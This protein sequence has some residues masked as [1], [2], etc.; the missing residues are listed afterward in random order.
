MKKI[1]FA[2]LLTSFISLS[3]T[4]STIKIYN[5]SDMVSINSSDF[6]QVKKLKENDRKIKEIENQS[7][8]VRATVF[9][10]SKNLD[11]TMPS[12]YGQVLFKKNIESHATATNNINVD[13]VS[14]KDK[15]DYIIK[16]K[17]VSGFEDF[18][19]DKSNQ[20]LR[21][22]VYKMNEKRGLMQLKENEVLFVNLTSPGEMKKA[23]MLIYPK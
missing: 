1:T 9:D 4:A 23:V 14:K 18:F 16:A 2:L 5:V 7:K 19:A 3:A 10:T 20:V 6:L 17:Y 12:T 21:M 8:L 13:I 11:V 22:P 15:M